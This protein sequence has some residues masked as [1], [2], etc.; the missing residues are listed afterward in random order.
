MKTA[1]LNNPPPAAYGFK[2]FG[3]WK[4]L[5]TLQKTQ[6]SCHRLW[7]H[8]WQYSSVSVEKPV[9]VTSSLQAA[10]SKSHCDIHTVLH[11]FRNPIK[12][13]LKGQIVKKCAQQHEILH[14]CY[15]Q[16]WGVGGGSLAER[17]QLD[18]LYVCSWILCIPCCAT[19]CQRAF[20]WAMAET[21]AALQMD[22]AS[23]SVPRKCSFGWAILFLWTTAPLLLR[24]FH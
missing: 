1:N 21:P 14:I 17:W 3:Q 23:C 4:L 11:C 8:M 24:Y 20:Y 15:T 19:V 22:A 2:S 13:G 9:G 5:L 12:T 7:V 10:A 18:I 16:E 6:V